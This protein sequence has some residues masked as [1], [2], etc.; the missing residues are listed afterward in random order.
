[1][2][3]QTVIL[4]AALMAA[5]SALINIVTPDTAA[6]CSC[7]EPSVESS[8]NSASDVAYVDVRRSYVLGDTRYFVGSVART[9]KGCL[10]AGQR[11]LLK[12]PAAGETCG[13]DLR[14]R[15][16]LINGS[17]VR[18]FLGTP[19][20][21][22]SLCSYDREV[23]QLTERDQKFLE[24]RNVCC[25]DQCA[26]ADGSQPVQCFAE[27]CSVAPPCD[28][29]VCEAN[30]CGGC[31]AEFYDPRG[32][33][34]CQ[35]PTACKS[36]DDCESDSW[37]RETAFDPTTEPRSECVP[38]VGEG[39]SCGGFTAPPDYE[40]C[41]PGLTCDAPSFEDDA[42][43]V[44]RPRCES[45]ADC[46]EGSYCASDRMCD[47]H[48]ACELELDC[49]MPGNNYAH[50]ACVGHGV[51][52]A[53]GRCGWACEAPECLDLLGFDFGPCDAVLGWAVIGGQCT[54]VSGCTAGEHVLFASEEAC[55]TTCPAD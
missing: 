49:S 54:N 16:Y 38:F 27:P 44:C 28:A 43:G 19:V 22:I 47:V 3:V 46:G 35:G 36:D 40:R 9:F 2:R 45:D 18:G 11:V 55:R 25:G 21:S 39:A 41:A 14:A 52:A 13:A 24:G 26:C 20:L 51:C 8:Y 31:R 23:S 33:P 10:R 12:T 50:I 15:R 4:H 29:G 42:P 1:M 48:G 53:Q 5:L 30:Y 32:E 34:V 37:C 7:V 17:R 6:A